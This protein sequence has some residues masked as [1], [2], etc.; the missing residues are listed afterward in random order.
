MIHHM[1]DFPI[2]VVDLM[3]DL[4]KR[5]DVQTV[6]FPYEDERVWRLLVAE[7]I[8][9]AGRLGLHLQ[10]SFGLSGPDSGLPFNTAAWGG[11]VHIPYEGMCGSDLIVKPSWRACDLKRAMGEGDLTAAMFGKTCHHL[12]LPGLH[13]E[14]DSATR[15][16]VDGWTLFTSN[17]PYTP[18][19]LYSGWKFVPGEPLP[20]PIAEEF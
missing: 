17:R 1:K 10:H 11:Y 12:L 2:T 16:V 14:V 8:L 9:R 7:Q 20:E 5:S 18:C 19:S 4:I 3:G 6:S 13:Q 15:T